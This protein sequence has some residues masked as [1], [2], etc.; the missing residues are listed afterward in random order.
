MVF[1]CDWKRLAI[2]WSVRLVSRQS[3]EHVCAPLLVVIYCICLRWSQA[4][5]EKSLVWYLCFCG[6]FEL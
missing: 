3:I 6:L 1:V 4:L 2:S 5:V